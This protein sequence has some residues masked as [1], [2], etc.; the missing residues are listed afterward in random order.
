MTPPAPTLDAELAAFVQGGVGIVVASRDDRLLASIAR[1]VGCRIDRGGQR[2]TVFVV[3][4][5][6]EALL[7]DVRRHRLVAVVF[8]QPSSHRT[9]Q[10]KGSDACE[11]A[12]EAEDFAAMNAY[13]AALDAELSGIGFG[14]GYA[15]ALIAH[16]PGDVV[17]VCFTVSDGYLQTPGPRAGERLAK[18]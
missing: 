14:N 3:R 4:S 2:V 7:A 9:V 18:P 17:G 15:R 8:S 11:R 12:P 6:N 16:A 10:L 13:A 5:E 1:G